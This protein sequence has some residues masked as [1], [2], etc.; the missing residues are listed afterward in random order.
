[1][2]EPADFARHAQYF[3]IECV[4]ETFEDVLTRAFADEHR[5]LRATL[6]GPVD[7]TWLSES[8]RER[9]LDEREQVFAEYRRRYDEL[10]RHVRD[11]HLQLRVELDEIERN[12]KGGRFTI[13]RNRRRV[14]GEAVEMARTLRRAGLVTGQIAD[15]LG[16]SF[17]HAQRLLRASEAV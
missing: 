17:K 3:G 7:L 13:G 14:N 9:I 1:V 5:K 11:C 2:S 6:P 10:L 16:V 12:R 15:K 4:L 8:E